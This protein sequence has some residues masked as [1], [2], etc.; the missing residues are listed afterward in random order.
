M[1]PAPYNSNFR[2]GIWLLYLAGLLAVL[3][4]TFSLTGDFVLDDWLVLSEH[5]II[6]NKLPLWQFFYF[7]Q[8][9][10]PLSGEVTTYRPLMPLI[11][12]PIWQ[13][14]PDNPFVFRLLTLFLHLAATASIIRVGNLFIKNKWVVAFAAVLF[15]V[16]AVHAETLGSIAHQNEILAFILCLWSLYF[17]EKK[18]TA[19][20]SVLLLIFAVLI[21]ESAIVFC[22]VI[23]LYLAALREMGERIKFV[24]TILVS[25][26]LIIGVQLSLDRAPFI[27]GSLDNLSYDAQGIERLL[28]GLYNI[29]RGITLMLVPSGLAPFHGY[30]A[31]D[32]SVET[33]LPYAILGGITLLLSSAGLLWAIWKKRPELVLG[34]SIFMG[35]LVLQSNLFIRTFAELSERWLY[36]PSLVVCFIISALCWAFFRKLQEKG[37]EWLGFVCMVAIVMVHLFISWNTLVAWKNNDSL[38]A[39]AVRQ[40]PASYQSRYFHAKYLLQKDETAEGLWYATTA[41][42]IKREY[43]E[44][45]GRSGRK[46]FSVLSQLD[47]QAVTER[48]RLAPKTFEPQQPCVYVR[49]SLIETA[50]LK[51]T[52]P[53]EILNMLAGMYVNQGYMKCFANS[54]GQDSVKS[55]Q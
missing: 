39:F 19:A 32:L 26:G 16:F 1:S 2:S 40:E 53:P 42:M 11:W 18:H 51:P 24:M 34:I 31:I 13:V 20:I 17:I 3:V 46:K 10:K 41:L 14:F 30:A 48:F 54:E 15:A 55:E 45:R 5:P 12:W 47:K 23:L 36:T 43:F 28:H 6:A 49:D 29:G 7:D 44:T 37:L 33:L 8:W 50:E 52:P 4:C 9:G 35:P 38:M 22:V 25:A 27:F 21:K